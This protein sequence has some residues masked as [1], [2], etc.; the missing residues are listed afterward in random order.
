VLVAREDMIAGYVC[1]RCG[2]LS[3][4]SD[5]C[6]DWGMGAYAVPDSV[7]AKLRFPVTGSP[8]QEA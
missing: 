4:G 8:Q 3:A 7:A 6:P 2:G 5:E 1:G